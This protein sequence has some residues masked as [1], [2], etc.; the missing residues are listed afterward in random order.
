MTDDLF[1]EPFEIPNT[2]DDSLLDLPNT[3]DEGFLAL[4]DTEDEGALAVPSTE[5]APAGKPLL[6]PRRDPKEE[7]AARGMTK[8]GEEEPEEPE[9]KPMLDRV[10][11]RPRPARQD[12]METALRGLNDDRMVKVAAQLSP[13]ELALA[14]LATDEELTEQVRRSLPD[15]RRSLFNQYFELGNDKVPDS[16][17]DAAQGKLLRV[18]NLS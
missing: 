2:E 5:K 8:K 6:L 9:G 12:R 3:E 18:I 11:S 1:G 16:A 14:L 17:I 4:P 7:S 10:R 15:E 13:E